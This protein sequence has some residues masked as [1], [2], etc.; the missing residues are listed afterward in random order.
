MIALDDFL[1]Q[2]QSEEV[3]VADE[4]QPIVVL[5]AATEDDIPF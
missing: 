2:A 1:C 5:S 3:I 4:S